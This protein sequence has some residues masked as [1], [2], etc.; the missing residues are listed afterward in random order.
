MN[1]KERDEATEKA[2]LFDAYTR[3]VY[4]LR[5]VAGDIKNSYVSTLIFSGN[6]KNTTLIGNTTNEG[7]IPEQLGKSFLNK[8]RLLLE[9]TIPQIEELREKL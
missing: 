9:E 7:Q 2:K 4:Q 8:F 5:G 3:S 1:Q 6:G